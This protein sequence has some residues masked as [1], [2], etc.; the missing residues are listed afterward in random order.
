[1]PSFAYSTLLKIDKEHTELKKKKKKSHSKIIIFLKGEA[2]L[3]L[4][5]FPEEAR[6]TKVKR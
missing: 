1:M 2:A 3:F 5:C 6:R 4:A